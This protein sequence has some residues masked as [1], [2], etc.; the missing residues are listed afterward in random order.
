MS[1]SIQFYQPGEKFSDMMK[2]PERA[3]RFG[4]GALVYSEIAA[5]HMVIEAYERGKREGTKGNSDG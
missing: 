4:K 1:E 2:P 3:E 5:R